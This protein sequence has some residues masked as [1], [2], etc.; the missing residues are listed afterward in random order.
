MDTRSQYSTQFLYQICSKNFRY[1]QG[2][3]LGLFRTS[4]KSLVKQPTKRIHRSSFRSF[5]VQRPTTN[6]NLSCLV[7]KESIHIVLGIYFRNGGCL[8]RFLRIGAMDWM[9][10]GIHFL[11]S[12][13][14]STWSTGLL[15]KCA[16]GRSRSIHGLFHGN[17]S[18]CM[19]YWRSFLRWRSLSIIPSI[20]LVTGS[21]FRY[22]W[23][24]LSMISSRYSTLMGRL[25]VDIWYAPHQSLWLYP[26]DLRYR[27]AHTIR[28][29]AYRYNR[30]TMAATSCCQPKLLILRRVYF[31]RQPQGLETSKQQWNLSS[32]HWC[33]RWK[34]S[35]TVRSCY[36][37]CLV[38]TKPIKT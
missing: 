4:K 37:D 5:I 2:L 36:W 9:A 16:Q 28:C 32:N 25:E 10:V 12:S 35:C 20:Y 8:D 15:A 27:G 23:F 6:D 11:F 13:C 19:I 21:V 14:D 3:G 17:D 18:Y 33:S 34:C 30:N 31:S 1:L 7:D 24:R 26:Y 22:Q 38:A 29:C